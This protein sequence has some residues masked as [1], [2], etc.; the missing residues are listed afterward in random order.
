M[1][2]RVDVLAVMD[3]AHRVLGEVA[4]K[5]RRKIGPFATQ[6]VRPVHMLPKA[7][8]AVA[9]LIDALNCAKPEI[10]QAEFVLRNAGATVTA[11]YLKQR[12]EPL[13]AA[14]AQVGGGQ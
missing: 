13:F 4:F 11:D 12:M 9:K 5:Y 14:L 3:D 10:Q 6:A 1:S 7:S 8:A 2:E